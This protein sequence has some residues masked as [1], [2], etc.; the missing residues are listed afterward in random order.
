MTYRLAE[1]SSYQFPSPLPQIVTK[2]SSTSAKVVAMSVVRSQAFT[3]HA[4]TGSSRARF[5]NLLCNLTPKITSI[6]K[7][8]KYISPI[9][10]S[11]GFATSL[12]QVNKISCLVLVT[13]ALMATLA[14]SCE[15]VPLR[16]SRSIGHH[17]SSHRLSLPS[18]SVPSSTGSEAAASSASLHGLDATSSLSI[19][20]S[21]DILRQNMVME[22]LRRKHRQNKQRQVQLN[23]EIL[24]RIG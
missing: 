2:C 7:S 21:L 12:L 18:I 5:N 6:C 3:N 24:D 1:D 11:C 4:S 22:I 14:G 13:I 20:S 8:T 9:R 16:P 19:V 15:A 23:K 10:R 17:H